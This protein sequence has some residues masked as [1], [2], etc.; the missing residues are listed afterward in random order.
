MLKS[1]LF[2]TVAIKSA[3][4]NVAILG[5]RIFTGLAMAIAHGFSKIPPSQGFIDATDNLGFPIPAFFS[6]A[7]ALSEFLG[8]LLIA[9][10]LLTRPA[11][12]FMGM[13][14][15]VAAFLRHSED[16]FNNKE[17]ALLYLCICI[18]LF[19]TG[20]GRYGIDSTLSPSKTQPYI[21]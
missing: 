2:G 21:R 17:K 15:M 7:A 8:G 20:S 18:F 12:L 5:L 9:L 10:G 4:T 1:F 6:W 14:M 11:A 13:T 16:P 19:L 3:T